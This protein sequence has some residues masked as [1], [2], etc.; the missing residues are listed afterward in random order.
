MLFPH[1]FIK[2]SVNHKCIVI[3]ETGSPSLYDH[4][5]LS[6]LFMCLNVNANQTKKTIQSQR[7]SIPMYFKCN[8]STYIAHVTWLSDPGHLD[9]NTHIQRSLGPQMVGTQ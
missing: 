5:F 9:G 3:C 2:C 6:I 4:S 1:I 7:H 8:K